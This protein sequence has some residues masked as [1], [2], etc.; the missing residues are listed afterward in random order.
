M[1]RQLQRG[2]LGTSKKISPSFRLFS[3]KKPAHFNC[4][5]FNFF[6]KSLSDRALRPPKLL[7]EGGQPRAT[8]H[9][10]LESGMCSESSSPEIFGLTI[11]GFAGA[12][13]SI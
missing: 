7:S 10:G 4:A 9:P 6:V 11:G 8:N 5:G 2:P 12:F 13:G 3:H 1:Y